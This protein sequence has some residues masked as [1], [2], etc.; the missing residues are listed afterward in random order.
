[1]LGVCVFFWGLGYKMSLYR[2]H[3]SGLHRIPEAKLLSRNEDRSA[4]DGVRLSLANTESALQGNLS[5]VFAL[6][7]FVSVAGLRV[8]RDRRYLSIPKLWSL[9][10]ATRSAFFLRPPP[11]F[12]PAFSL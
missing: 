8:D 7:A 2:P 10:F 6:L 9:Q 1:M 12:P 4:S 5:V 11:I 3:P